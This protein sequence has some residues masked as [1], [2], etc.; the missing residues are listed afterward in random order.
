MRRAW[1]LIG[2]A[3]LLILAGC[4]PRPSVEIHVTA[5]PA[6]EAAIER[7]VSDYD[8]EAAFVLNPASGKFH[9]PGCAW[10]QRI[11][12]ERRIEYSGDRQNLVD[13]G[14]LPCHYCEP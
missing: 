7:A 13:V 8:T 14:Y 6:P 5:T 4:G 12:P 2:A 9:R 11:D 10:A 1:A 3:A